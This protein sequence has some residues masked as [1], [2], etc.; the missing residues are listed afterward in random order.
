MRAIGSDVFD[1]L[2][3]KYKEKL[4]ECGQD[5]PSLYE[6]IPQKLEEEVKIPV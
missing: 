5:R 6:V 2:I 1:G 3:L 4:Q